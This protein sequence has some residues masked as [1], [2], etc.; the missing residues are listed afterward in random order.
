MAN[1]P[2]ITY[3]NLKHKV[4]NGIID[5][6]IQTKDEDITVV[7]NNGVGTT[8]TYRAS[9]KSPHNQITG[10]LNSNKELTK[11]EARVTPAEIDDYGPTVGKCAATITGVEANTDTAFTILITSRVFTGSPTNTYR[12]CLMGQSSL[13]YS[14]D[15][16]QLY[17]VINSNAPFTD[18][19]TEVEYIESTGTQYI[20]TNVDLGA[21]N[22]NIKCKF[23]NTQTTE[24]EQAILSIWTSTYNYWNCFIDNGNLH[25]IDLFLSNHVFGDAVELNTIYDLLISRSGSDW[26]MSLNG[27]E[28]TKSYTPTS[29]NNT[30]LKLFTRGDIPSTDRSN[31]HIKMYSCQVIS[32]EN[33]VRDLVPCIRNSDNKPGLYDKVNKV[34]YTNQGSDEFKYG[35]LKAVPQIYQQVKYIESTGT[36]YINTGVNVGPN[37]I[38]ELDWQVDRISNTYGSWSVLYGYAGS[39]AGYPYALWGSANA[40]VLRLYK[41]EGTAELTIALPIARTITTIE[42]NADAIDKQI[43]VFSAGPDCGSYKDA[44]NPYKLYGLKIYDNSQLVRNFIPCY[45]KSDV[46]VGLLDLINNVFYINE[47]SDTFMRGNDINYTKYKPVD[48]DGYDVHFVD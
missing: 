28:V 40:N 45:R 39:S 19:Y 6:V 15:C 2:T 9:F 44:R 10:I 20:D 12:I 1:F 16:T 23:L 17:M 13:D 3:T 18:T 21:N 29:T 48:A 32:N 25:N 26:A 4:D 31:T 41:K 30:T 36:Q 37:I 34:F 5:G 8:S 43:Y 14:W 24:A 42:S 22:F 46:V 38:S 27:S 35:P 47:G 7:F 33:L 11:W